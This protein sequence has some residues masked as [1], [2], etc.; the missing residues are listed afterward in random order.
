MTGHVRITLMAFLYCF[1]G[2]VSAVAADSG[3][4]R[5]AMIALEQ[6]PT[7]AEKFQ[8]LARAAAA[9]DATP[10]Q[11]RALA[12]CCL[13]YHLH[14]QPANAAKAKALLQKNHGNEY[15]DIVSDENLFSKRTCPSCKEGTVSEPCPNCKSGQCPGCNGQ[16]DKPGLSS[17]ITCTVCR[18]TGRCKNCNGA[19]ELR[20]TCRACRGTGG[21]LEFKR[22]AVNEAYLKL[23]R[24]G[25]AGGGT[26]VAP[27]PA[28]ADGTQPI[29]LDASQVDRLNQ[30]YNAATSLNK[31]AVHQAFLKQIGADEKGSTPPF[32]PVEDGIRFIVQDVGS[33]LRK[34]TR[35]Y[36]A[37][38]QD[39]S[40]KR[41]Y[42]LMLGQDKAFA[43]GLQKGSTLTSGGWLSPLTG[44]PPWD[45]T[46]SG[47]REVYRYI[48][49]YMSMQ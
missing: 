8:A 16:G 47:F 32:L 33:F 49:E 43:E 27:L 19:G 46:L 14:G 4:I 34:N 38:L 13:G 31:A 36:Y 20:W 44:R 45:A 35:Y 37:S 28:G 1:W 24:E 42:R 30:E 21:A 23:L 11:A 29:I 9:S 40:G 17:R 39:D 7:H 12:V 15:Q 18:G 22:D 10:E 41:R 48:G 25:T 6:D 2:L 3:S 5:A 26:T